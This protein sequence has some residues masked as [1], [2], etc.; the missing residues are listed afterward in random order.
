M[1]NEANNDDFEVIPLVRVID[2]KIWFPVKRGFFS[3]T[4]A[5]VRAVDGVNLE[6]R[7]GEVLGLVGESGCGKTTLGRTL[8]GLEKASSGDILFS[9]RSLPQLSKGEMNHLRQRMQVIFQDPMSSLNPRMTVMDIITE[10]LVQFKRIEGSK[11]AHAKRLLA[12]V[13]LSEDALYRFPHEFSGGQRQR[14]S[15]AR[16]ISLRPEL[17][18][19]DEAVSALDVSIQAQVVN[20]LKSLK[21]R[22][23][24]SLLF[25]SHDLSVVSNIADRT[26]VMYLGRIL[27]SGNTA[28]IVRAPLHPYTR[29]LIAAVPV[30]GVRR[31]ERVILTGEIPSALSPPSGCRFHPR[32]PE[33]M[34]VCSRQAP[35]ASWVDGRQVWCH[36]YQG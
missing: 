26:A 11:A 9:G 10:G 13:G 1:K 7:R 29:A 15:I 18:I 33:V 22:H 16:A 31:P 28:D 17:V 36:L 6:I 23:H 32:C 14:I 5:Y 27:E 35:S 4:A 20:L 21:E 34:P 30:P 12:E 24:L 8:L 3:K 2:L 25:I 19:C